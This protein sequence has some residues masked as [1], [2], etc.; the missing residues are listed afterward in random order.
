MLLLIFFLLSTW[1]YNVQNII[2]FVTFTPESGYSCVREISSFSNKSFRWTLLST[3][4]GDAGLADVKSQET[5]ESTS[6][7][8]TCARLA[9]GITPTEATATDARP[10]R[11]NVQTT[12]RS[13]GNA[14]SAE[15]WWSEDFATSVKSTT[16]QGMNGAYDLS[17]SRLPRSRS[18]P[19][20]RQSKPK[21]G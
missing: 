12:P 1:C 8:A 3:P 10:W 21:E 7:T 15:K 13:I 9:T 14:K 11:R 2:V 16:C 4:E 6:T 19:E 5:F 20:R 17:I 18:R